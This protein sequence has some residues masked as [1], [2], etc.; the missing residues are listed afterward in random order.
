M[1]L[2]VEN[3]FYFSLEIGDIKDVLGTED[4][5]SFILI[6]Q[7]GNILPTF[8]FTFQSENE[9]LISRLHEG[10]DIKV[11]FGPSRD[12]FD[13]IILTATKLQ[14]EQKGKSLNVYSMKGFSSN[15]KYSQSPVKFISDKKSGVEV[16]IEKARENFKV[17]T[18]VLSSSD[19]QYWIQH[20]IPNRFFINEVWMHSYIRNSFL[21]C[22]ITANNEFILKDIKQEI[23]NKA[24]KPDWTFSATEVGRDFVSYASDFIVV[25]KTGLVNSLVGQGRSELFYDLSSGSNEIISKEAEAIFALTRNIAKRSDLEKR[26]LGSNATNDNVHSN[27]WRAYKQNLTGNITLGAITNIINIKGGYKR[28]KPLD[29]VVF[30]SPSTI[31]ENQS[32][33]YFSGSYIINKTIKTIS[34]NEFN[35]AVEICRESMN[36]V[37]NVT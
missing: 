35:S 24:D 12:D 6:E 4:L 16:I 26:F 34:G 1:I 11:Q 8:E 32:Q 10:T 20:N 31:D 14:I 29:I 25:S 9:K 2:G 27:Y 15:L 33:E 18:N 37:K 23:S 13:D 30:K 17:K 36:G 28:L 7:A 21:S 19:S 5:I 22:A 3:Q